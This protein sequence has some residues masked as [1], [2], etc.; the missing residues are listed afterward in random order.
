MQNVQTHLADRAFDR[1]IGEILLEQRYFNGV[2][3]RVH[4]SN[5]P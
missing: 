3:A 4:A 2:R 5:W 1:P